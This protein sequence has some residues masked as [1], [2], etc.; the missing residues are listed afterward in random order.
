MHYCMVVIH[1]I[2]PRVQYALHVQA[3]TV[4]LHTS[5]S[6]PL[7]EKSL[8]AYVYRLITNRSEGGKNR[9]DGDDAQLCTYVSRLS[10]NLKGVGLLRWPYGCLDIRTYV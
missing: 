8:K 10:R 1:L 2:I 4:K 7:I 9:N 5:Q 3:L 6:P